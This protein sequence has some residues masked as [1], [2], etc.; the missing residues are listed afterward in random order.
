MKTILKYS[1]ALPFIIL[2]AIVLYC[3]YQLLASSYVPSIKHILALVLVF[4]N[5]GLFFWNYEK[6]E[7]MTGFILLLATFSLIT[8]E[9]EVVTHSY[10][11]KIGE[12]KIA[13][14]EINIL[15][16]LILILYLVL[17]YKTVKNIVKRMTIY[18]VEAYRE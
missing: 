3:W 18:V 1:G 8:I 15:S 2:C 14:P 6:G 13:T 10:F 12:T 11:I 17:H 5:A 7:L 16:L 9:A 4:V